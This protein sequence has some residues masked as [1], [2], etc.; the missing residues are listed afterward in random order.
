M[1][2]KLRLKFIKVCAISFLIVFALLFTVIEIITTNQ[3]KN[4]LDNLT[5]IIAENNGVLPAYDKFLYSQLSEKLKLNK[6]TPFYTRYF[7]VDFD[8]NNKPVNVNT[9]YIASITQK[10]A[11]RLAEKVVKSGN[12]RGWHNN[13]RYKV[14]SNSQGYSAV[15]V[16]ANAERNR[17]K[18]YL[19]TAAYVFVGGGVVILLLI[20]II[21]KQVVKPISESYEKQK[22]FI[23]DAN[24]ELKTPLTLIRTNLDIAES[25]LGKN[26]WLSDIREESD[27]MLELV[28]QLVTLARMDEDVNQMEFHTFNLSDAVTD[29]VS[30]FTNLAKS[31]DKTIHSDIP[32]NIEL[33][34]D[35][36]A[37][38]QLT[39][40]ILDNAIKYSDVGGEICV[41]INDSSRPVLMI[42]NTYSEVNSLNFEH[43]FD[44]FYRENKARTFGSGFG[45]GLSI[46]KGIVE[47]HK[48]NISAFKL[49]DNMIRIQVKF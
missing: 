39:S 7:T 12:S 20:V 42:D 14:Y 45:V 38:R 24:H 8:E 23:T 18:E 28:N 4:S 27:M 35:E 21:S 15:F 3:T 33:T 5:D 36:T 30:T 32:K 46:A 37:I 47:K 31:K 22:Q 26:E 34:G 25:E 41:T 19:T 10:K 48:G 44:R 6:E 13:F 43:L 1:I 49:T 9:N 2:N 29:T 17:N 40:I 11:I 16:R